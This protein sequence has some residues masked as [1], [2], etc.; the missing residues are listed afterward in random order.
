M[1]RF[2]NASL[3]AAPFKGCNS[4]LFLNIILDSDI[5]TNSVNHGVSLSIS[6]IVALDNIPMGFIF[7]YPRFFLYNFLAFP[8]IPVIDKTLSY[9][10]V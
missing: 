9:H 8:K 6:S 3:P 7:Y 1:Y 4:Q 10:Q 2:D 5:C